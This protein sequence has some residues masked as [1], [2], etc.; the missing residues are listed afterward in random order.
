MATAYRNL[1]ELK[2]KRYLLALAF[3]VL[4]AT[5]YATIFEVGSGGYYVYS[6]SSALSDSAAEII[7]EHAS[8]AQLTADDTIELVSAQAADRQRVRVIGISIDSTKLEN[9]VRLNGTAVVATDSTYYAFEY[10]YIDSGGD[11]AGAV[12]LRDAS[13]DVLI[14]TILATDLS[15]KVAHK[16]FP[17]ETGTQYLERWGGGLQ[18]SLGA[19]RVEL[20]MYDDP[21]DARDLTD[22]F[23]QID[24][25]T[26]E[27]T[28]RPFDRNLGGIR[29]PRNAYLAVFATS[30]NGAPLMDAFFQ[31]SNR[32]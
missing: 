14:T 25:V 26:L 17:R 18:D 3:V 5:A 12:T 9:V 8:F 16:F 23:F 11:L 20:R 29:I 2:M 6:P 22:G 7:A 32:R 30:K 13:G 1:K 15:T 27:N 19:V 31:T 10:A 28:I 21:L 4:A 24:E